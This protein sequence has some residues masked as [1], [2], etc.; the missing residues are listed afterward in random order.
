MPVRQHYLTLDG[1]RGLV[2]ISV[3]FFHIVWQNGLGSLSPH[4]YLG[5]DFF[6]ALS[7]FVIAIA[8]DAR[9]QQGMGFKQFMIVRLRRLYPLFALGMALSAAVFILRMLPKGE[10]NTSEFVFASLNAFLISPF[11]RVEGNDYLFPFN[12]PAWSLFFEV[13]INAVYALAVTYL[14]LPRLLGVLAASAVA[15][16]VMVTYHGSFDVGDSSSELFE[17]AIR[18]TFSF[19][20]GVLLGRLMMAGR[21]RNM[22]TVSPALLSVVLLAIF[23]FPVTRFNFIFELVGVLL[24]FP[25]IVML[26]AVREPSSRF[27]ALAKFSGLISYPLYIT[28]MPVVLISTYICVRL[29]LE[30]IA[31]FTMIGITMVTAIMLAYLA[32]VCF[33][34]PIRR[35]FRATSSPL[36]TS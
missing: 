21:L 4:G 11:G 33:D 24:V 7:G 36:P 6:F 16:I 20:G 18:V 19:S 32:A 30:G 17:G 28:H 31:L 8:Y 23:L 15:A 2:A 27:E 3:L 14:T 26:G 34:E 1:L 12:S 13:A 25:L 35:F 9:L 5:V 29:K 22:P 10:F